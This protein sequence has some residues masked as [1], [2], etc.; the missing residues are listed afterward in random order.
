MRLFR[1]GC[2]GRA[3]FGGNQ[4][5]LPRG[6]IAMVRAPRCVFT[7]DATSYWSAERCRTIVRL[8]SPL[9]LNIRPRFASYAAAS[10]PSPIGTRATCAPLVASVTAITLP[11]HTE[12]SR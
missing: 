5:H 6:G 7:V 11:S 9:E 8:P 4:I 3:E 12:N 2:G 1:R 10:G